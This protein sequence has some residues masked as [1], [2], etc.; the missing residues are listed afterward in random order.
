M[1]NQLF[2]DRVIGLNLLF[3]ANP[4]TIFRHSKVIRI[5]STFLLGN[6]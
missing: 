6:F 5:H 3:C 4:E 1:S 2:I